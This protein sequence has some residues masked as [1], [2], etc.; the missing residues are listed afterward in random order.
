LTTTVKLLIVED[1]EDTKNKMREVFKRSH[2]GKFKVDFNSCDLTAKVPDLSFYDVALI[3]FHNNPEGALA[4]ALRLKASNPDVNMAALAKNI[5]L[6]APIEIL[7]LGFGPPVVIDEE[8]LASLPSVALLLSQGE[9]DEKSTKLDLRARH[10]EL[11][12]ITDSLARQSVHLIRLRD[13]LAAEK[14]KVEAIINGMTD[15]VIFF[16]SA[17][18]M[19]MIN[20]VAERLFPRLNSVGQD[21]LLTFMLEIKKNSNKRGGAEADPE[22]VFETQIGK[23]NFLVRQTEV[24]DVASD[25]TGSLI[26]LTDITAEKKYERLKNDFTSMIS[27]ELRTPLTSI[28]AAVDNFLRGVLG[29]VTERQVTFLNIIARN[30]DRQR[31]LVDNLLDLAKFEA[32]QMEVVMDKTNLAGLAAMSVE[33]FSFAFQDKNIKLVSEAQKGGLIINADHKLLVQAINNLLINALK[34]T[35]EGGTVKVSTSRKIVNGA[36]FAC[37]EVEDNGIGIPPDRLDKIFD[38]Y[39]Q[40]DSGAS[41]RYGGT[42]LGLAICK[43]IAHAHK[44][45]ITV[46]SKEGQWSRFSLYIPTTAERVEMT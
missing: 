37:V 6:F 1:D 9:S 21:A 17:G 18:T 28:K 45:E 3:D 29:E 38:K 31:E 16:D 8:G 32:N 46:E 44:G 33:Q 10:Q 22:N 41:R 2:V 13:E 19:E 5:R 15:G 23:Q 43:Q 34:F 27:H 20:P 11:R 40:A 30:V 26:L 7:E 35:N 24:A 12:N 42:G 36:T 14:N 39:T 4:A 25:T